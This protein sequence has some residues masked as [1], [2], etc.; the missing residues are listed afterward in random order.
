MVS[1]FSEFLHFWKW[2]Y[3]THIIVLN[4]TLPRYTTPGWT[5]SS[6]RTLE[7]FLPVFHH[8]MLL[9]RNPMSFWFS[10]F[11][12]TLFPLSH[13]HLKILVF[14]L[15]CWCS[16]ISQWYWVFF[17]LSIWIWG[18]FLFK[19][20]KISCITFYDNFLCFLFFLSGTFIVKCSFPVGPLCLIILSPFRALSFVFYFLGGLLNIFQLFN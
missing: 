6:S 11:Y 13:S 19:C 16:E 17:H 5:Q 18:L 12:R 4:D 2:F 9:M 1:R 3:F 10:F 15:C 8:P 7:V 14:S 20:M